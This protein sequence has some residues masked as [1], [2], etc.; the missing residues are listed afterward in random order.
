MQPLAYTEFSVYKKTYHHFGLGELII[1]LYLF[2]DF[3]K[4]LKQ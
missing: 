4:I 1:T 2:M 3:G